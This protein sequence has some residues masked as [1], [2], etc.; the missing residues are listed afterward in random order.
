M[1]QDDKPVDDL[2]NRRVNSAGEI[3]VSAIGV[4]QLDVLAGTSILEGAELQR[5]HEGQIGEM[6]TRLP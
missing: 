4:T 5:S 1:A 6:L 3:V 2:H